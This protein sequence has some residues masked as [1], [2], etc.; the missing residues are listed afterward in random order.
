MVSTKVV[1]PGRLIKVTVTDRGSE[2][3]R[4]VSVFIWIDCGHVIETVEYIFCEGDSSNKGYV[5]VGKINSPKKFF[6]VKQKVYNL[7]AGFDM[8]Q[9]EIGFKT[10]MDNIC[11]YVGESGEVE[12]K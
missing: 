12:W 11:P 8:E 3:R 4:F 6:A 9:H 1:I 5:C 2:R 10:I 7:L